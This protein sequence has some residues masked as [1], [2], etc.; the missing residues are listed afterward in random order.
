MSALRSL[1]LVLALAASPAFAADSPAP[2]LACLDAQFAALPMDP[3]TDVGL[4]VAML[5]MH[6]DWSWQGARGVADREAGTPL[7]PEH[8]FRIASITKTFT[9]AAVL[10]LVEQGRLGLHDPIAKHLDADVVAVLESGGYDPQAI[11]LRHVL[12]HTSGMREHVTEDFLARHGDGSGYQSTAR[13]QV[14]LAMAA[15][16]PFAAPGDEFHYSDT[17]YVLLGLVI[18]RHTGKPLH[19]A[20]RSLQAWEANGLAHSWFETLEPA[21]APQ[22]HQYWQGRD[23]RPWH[24]SFDLYGGGGIVAPPGDT[25]AF[26]RVLL[27]GGLFER[28]G[29]LKF[30]RT[31][32]V[33]GAWNDYGAGLFNL[34][35]DGETMIGHSG[36]WNTFVFLS[37]D[38]GVIFAG[39]VGEKTALPYGP[40]LGALRTAYRTCAPG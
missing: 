25:A 3:A 9:A 36:Y 18:E 4:S 39:A 23:T 26:L 21:R 20:L 11:R 19:E 10:R 37:P 14:K 28:P 35:V 40:L 29:S 5:P 1:P 16:A 34:E 12:N 33:T 15:G 31:P 27:K 7:T 8:G 32:G 24:A 22:A 13:E 6:D 38:D 2:L 17:G 30:M